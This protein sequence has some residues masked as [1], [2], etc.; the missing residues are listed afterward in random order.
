MSRPGS[1]SVNCERPASPHTA[2]ATGVPVV[3]RKIPAS[4]GSTA[5][6]HLFAGDDGPFRGNLSQWIKRKRASKS[7]NRLIG[8]PVDL[9]APSDDP[10]IKMPAS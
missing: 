5:P 8:V 10:A 6:D 7:L 9:D 2:R 1:V 3:F 4:D